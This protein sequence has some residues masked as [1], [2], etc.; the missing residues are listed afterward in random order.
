MATD[1]PVCG[2]ALFL[3]GDLQKRQEGLPRPAALAWE[4]AAF[5]AVFDDPGPGQRIRRFLEKA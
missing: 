2:R 4:R 5:A 1:F 3:L